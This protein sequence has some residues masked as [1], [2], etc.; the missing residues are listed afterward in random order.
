[1][2]TAFDDPNLVAQTG[3]VRVRRLAERCGLSRLPAEKVQL[4]G[5]TNGARTAANTKVCAP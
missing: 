3:L 5:T 2:S 1:M 4:T